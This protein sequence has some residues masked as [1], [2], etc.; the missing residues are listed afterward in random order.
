MT[1][2][3]ASKEP[4]IIIISEPPVEKKS[5]DYREEKVQIHVPKSHHSHPNEKVKTSL[6]QTSKHHFHLHGYVKSHE[7]TPYHLDIWKRKAHGKE[8]EKITVIVRGK[9]ASSSDQLTQHSP[10]IQK[11]VETLNKFQRECEKKEKKHHHHHHHHHKPHS[12]I[13]FH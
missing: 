7:E 3:I 12:H 6:E 4:V 5:S 1:S 11:C 9:K 10:V 8:K 2:Q 13:K